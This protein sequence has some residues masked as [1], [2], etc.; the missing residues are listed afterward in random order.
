[1]SFFDKFFGYYKDS[2][3]DYEWYSNKLGGGS[4]EDWRHYLWIISVPIISVLFF[5]YIKRNPDKSRKIIVWLAS[6]LLVGRITLLT[7]PVFLGGAQPVGRIFPFHQC[8]VMG[9]LLPLVIF[10]KLDKFKHPI[11]VISIMGALATIAF[12]EYFQST[13]LNYYFFEGIISHTLLLLIPLAEIARGNFKLDIKKSWTVIVGMLMLLSWATLAN[14]VFFAK[15]NSNY[16]F[17]ERSGFPDGFGGH[18]FFFIYVIIFIIVF[19]II[20]LS[21]YLYSKWV[22]KR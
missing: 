12:G 6:I 4:F 1:M 14:K 7:F 10:F 2:F 19:A 22:Q 18:Y 5:K 16:M 20:Y 3:G 8:A 9:V 17:L 15:Y 13:F 11:Y 21:P